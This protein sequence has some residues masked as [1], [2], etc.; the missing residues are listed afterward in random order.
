MQTDRQ[1]DRPALFPNALQA[2]DFVPRTFVLPQDLR[3]LKREF[4]E[5]GAK[6]KWILKPVSPVI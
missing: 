5:G 4:D 1:T 2:C 6:Q 3:K